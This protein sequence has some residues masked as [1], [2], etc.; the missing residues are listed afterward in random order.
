[1]TVY[2]HCGLPIFA[3]VYGCTCICIVI[4]HQFSGNT[5]DQKYSCIL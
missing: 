3:N 1:M 4:S 2:V 5:C